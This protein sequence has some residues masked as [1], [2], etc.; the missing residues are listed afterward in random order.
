MLISF[1]EEFRGKNPG[2]CPFWLAIAN[3]KHNSLA[4]P[5]PEGKAGSFIPADENQSKKKEEAL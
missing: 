1:F 4:P 5:L 2:F 3:Q